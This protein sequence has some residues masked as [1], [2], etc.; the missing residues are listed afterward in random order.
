MQEE[1]GNIIQ[2]LKNKGLLKFGDNQEIIMPNTVEQQMTFLNE[3]HAGNR[4]ALRLKL[5][6]EQLERTRID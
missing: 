3:E 6:N 5:E 1:V 2:Q 4:E